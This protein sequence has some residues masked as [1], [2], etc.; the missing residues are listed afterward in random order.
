M[1]TKKSSRSI[2]FFLLFGLL[3]FAPQIPEVKAQKDF[4][5]TEVSLQPDNAAQTGKCPLPVVFKGYIKANGKGRVTYTFT[6]SDGATGPVHTLD[7]AKAGE[8]EISTG[9]T[10]GDASTLPHYEGWQTVKI[11]SPNE[12]ESSQKIGTF[13]ITCADQKP[14]YSP[15]KQAHFRITINGLKVI[16]QT[17][18][19]TPARNANGQGDGRGDEAYFLSQ[20]RLTENNRTVRSSGLLR[21]GVIRGLATGD[22]FPDKTS[23]LA[24]SASD[25]RAPMLLFDGELKPGQVLVVIPT[26][27]EQDGADD[28]GSFINRGVNIANNTA[29]TIALSPASGSEPR[30]L[31]DRILAAA[32]DLGVDLHIAGSLLEGGHDRPLGM[33]LGPPNDYVFLAQRLRLNLADADE[34]SET[35]FGYGNGVI[36]IS[37][38]DSDTLQG[39]YTIFVQIQRL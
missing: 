28:L 14:Q 12:M 26:V 16:R 2:L 33:I 39:N 8:K 23:V 31:L 11:L 19:D 13:A 24:C 35:N 32:S 38:V 9:W 20:W 1:Y 21:G 7:F 22:S 36:P 27:W 30:G 15:P 25:A 6:R 18:D 3:C 5:V 34:A 10:L 4:S 17:L 29:F 37:Y